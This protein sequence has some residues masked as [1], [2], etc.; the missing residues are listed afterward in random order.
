MVDGALIPSWQ[1]QLADEL[2]KP[3]MQELKT[4]LKNQVEQKKTIYP[5]AKNYFAALNST[6]FE[7]VR[8][9]IL[10]QDPYHGP[11]QAHGLS[12][13][14]E[15]GVDIPPSLQN[16]YKELHMD[17]GFKM[18]NH[19]HL[20]SWAQQGVLLLNSVLSVEAGKAASHQGK[21]WEHFT[22]KII[23][24][25]NDGLEHVVFML[26]GSHA[27]KK[28]AQV[29]R[30]KHLVLTAPHPSPLSAYRGFLGSKHF[31]KANDY[32]IKNG[33]TPIDW[34]LPDSCTIEHDA[35]V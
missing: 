28:G 22:D 11:R 23:Q 18:V 30:K 13:S 10:G 3:Y 27:Q 25:V 7:K 2:Q 31:S 12:F 9:V 35:S 17:V 5:R 1:N 19:G 33:R 16:I 15:P 32:L 4:F 14:V 20:M 34:Q 21:G 26:W 6:P 8:V 24:C 29:D